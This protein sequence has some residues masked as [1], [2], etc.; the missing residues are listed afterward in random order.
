MPK[1]YTHKETH[2]SMSFHFQI[3]KIKYKE[4][5]LEKA[6]EKTV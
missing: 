4:K 6:V 3:P 2:P 1:T 5:V